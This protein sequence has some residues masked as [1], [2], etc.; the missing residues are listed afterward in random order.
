VSTEASLRANKKYAAKNKEKLKARN[1]AYRMKYPNKVLWRSA[2]ARAMKRG[3]EFT[4]VLEDVAIPSHC[5]VLGFA[6]QSVHGAYG[7]KDSSPSI[8]RID[9]SKGYTKENIQVISLKANMMKSSATPEELK[10]FAEWI[11]RTYG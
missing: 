2:K 4:I 6:L 1:L 9:P 7:G 5:P 10:I 11:K 8:D 3:I